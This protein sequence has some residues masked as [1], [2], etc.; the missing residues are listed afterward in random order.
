LRAEAPGDGFG[1]GRG[2][3]DVNGDGHADLIVA[4]YTSSAGAEF[5]GRALV[6]NGADGT[7]FRA[8]TSTIAN[9]NFGVDALGIGGADGDGFTDFVVTAV[10][11]A[12]A[13]TGPGVV[14]VV[15][16]TELP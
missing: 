6:I 7:T 14:Y 9:D 16:G 2:T 3:G 8:I 13:G 4:S 11:Q 12:F 10:G 5:A 1:P 15:K